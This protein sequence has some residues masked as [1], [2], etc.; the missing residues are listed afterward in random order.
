M[1]ENHDQLPQYVE[2]RGLADGAEIRMTTY[3]GREHMIVPVVALVGN[4]VVRGANSK[5]P[6][7]VPA[8]VLAAAPA[9]WNGRPVVSGHPNGGS[10][11]AND[12]EFLEAEAFG[13]LFHTVFNDNRLKPE[14][15]LD[16]ARAEEMGGEPLNTLERLKNREMI[17]VS[18]GAFIR[19]EP[20]SGF[21]NG[22]RYDYVWLSVVPDHLA[23]LPEGRPGACSNR[24]GCGGPRV[25]SAEETEPM[26]ENDKSFKDH[27]TELA[28]NLISLVREDGL[29]DVEVRDAI[30]RA[31]NAD[32]PGFEGV[33]EVFPKVKAVVYLTMLE[34]S[35]N[36]WR[37]TFKMNGE[38]KVTLNDDAAEVK[39]TVDWRALLARLAAPNEEEQPTGTEA[40]DCG[41]DNG[42]GLAAPTSTEGA[43]MENK[44]LVERLIALA[45]SP[46]TDEDAETL[47][48]LCVNKLEA[49]EKQY[50]DAVEPNSSD[51]PDPDAQAAAGDETT[52]ELTEDEWLEAHPRVNSMVHAFQ[53]QDKQK[54]ESLITALASKQDGYSKDELV[55][56]STDA[57]AQLAKALKIDEP[58]Q[59][60]SLVGQRRPG[61][62]ES[63]KPAPRGWDLALEKAKT[64]PN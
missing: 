21:H 20:R 27:V 14:V 34:G 4:I 41:S 64:A 2:L 61:D 36:F 9:G 59:D 45:R 15:W 29:S 19:T 51:D 24:D 31:V 46:F 18:I 58:V 43:S 30:G 32:V 63:V 7:F 39:E 60:Y 37:R 13:K 1:S 11:S 55:A 48:A 40:C 62:T 54:R 5:G 26:P 49:L 25:M 57:L 12:P 3:E 10:S 33:I 28:T 8:K 50:A 35:M 42:D 52:A 16:T 53:A 44:E 6:E 22:Q 56:M 47:A 23:L 38:G 17:E